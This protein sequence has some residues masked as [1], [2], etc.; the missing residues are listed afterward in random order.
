MRKVYFPLWI[1]VPTAVL[2][3]TSI[4]V[5]SLTG[6]GHFALGLISTGFFLFVTWK[7][8][9]FFG[10]VVG[11][12]GK[13][14]QS[15]ISL[16]IVLGIKIPFIIGLCFYIQS[17]EL[18]Q[19]GCFLMGLALVYSWLIGWAQSQPKTSTDSSTNGFSEVQHNSPSKDR[20]RSSS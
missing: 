11:Q 3:I 2:I 4:I 12:G 7:A 17:L 5:G 20:G 19:Q 16:F 8:I 18:R 6:L 13:P 9:Q 14:G 15:L 1:Q 10:T